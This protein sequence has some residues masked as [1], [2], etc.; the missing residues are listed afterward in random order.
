M[1]DLYQQQIVE[2]YKNPLHVGALQG[3][4]HTADGANLSCGD[5]IRWEIQI[6]DGTVSNAQHI[7]R[8]CAVCTAS[9][10]LLAD[11]LIGKSLSELGEIDV[12]AHLQTLGIPLSPIR[13]K[14]AVL[15]IETLRLLKQ[16]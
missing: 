2:R 5:E 9:A 11:S 8:A 12:E 4:T 10:D 14:C 15:P 3:A 16:A 13:R 1:L 6:T 7:S